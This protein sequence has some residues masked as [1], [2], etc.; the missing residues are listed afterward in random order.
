[1]TGARAQ[2]VLDAAEAAGLAQPLL[3]FELHGKEL[4][5]ETL[6][7][8]PPLK[9][10]VP[11]RVSGRDVVLLLPADTLQQIQAKVKGVREA[12]AVK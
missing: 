2:R 8:Y 5:D 3:T 4:G 12:K 11:A 7:L 10:G 9:D 6:T 1:V